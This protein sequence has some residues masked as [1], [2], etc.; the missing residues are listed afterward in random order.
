MFFR[1]KYSKSGYVLQ[2]LESYR[3]K[4]NQPRSKVI[5][6]LGSA[7]IAK[8]D[9]N[10]IARGIE[11]H[12]SGALE[13][14]PERFPVRIQKW[15]DRLIKQ[16][17]RK[18]RYTSHLSSKTQANTDAE[19][20]RG[21]LKPVVIPGVL[22]REVT[23]SHTTSLG[24]ELI[25]HQA[26]QH[27]RMDELLHRLGFNDTQIR[28]ATVS[29]INRLIDPVSEHVLPQWVLNTS[30]PELL[31]KGVQG[32]GK[33]R[34][35]RVSD[36]LLQ[37]KERIEAH[38]R[39]QQKEL[40]HLERTV[41][42]YDLTNSH[43]E[44]NCARNPKAKRGKNKQKRDDCL[45]IVVGML[46]DAH[47]FE[48]GHKIFEGNQND[49][50]S[51]LTMIDE[52]DRMHAAK[53]KGLDSLIKPLVV[54]D[55]GVATRANLK[56]LRDKKYSYLVNDSRRARKKY[57][58]Q[59]Q[60]EH[61]FEVIRDRKKK[62]EV[63]VCQI[64]DPAMMEDPTED[65]V[66]A[67]NTVEMENSPADRLLLCKSDK[68]REKELAMLSNA[69]KHFLAALQKLATRIEKGHLVDADKIQRCLGGIQNKH[70]R[71]QRHYHLSYEAYRPKAAPR[72]PAGKLTWIRQ[73]DSYSAD[74]ALLGCYVLRTNCR[75]FSSQEFWK[76]YMAL[77]HAEN[78][79]R[80]LKSNLG[81]RPNRHHVEDRVDAHVFI[82]ILAYDLLRTIL[83][84]LESKGDHRSWETIKRIMQT[85]CYTTMII[86]TNDGKV[87]RIRKPGE[88]EQGQR[89]IYH[90]LGVTLNNLP[91]M[92][93]IAPEDNM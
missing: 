83:Y 91:I 5:L 31:G 58:A 18:G 14:F 69:E 35:Y 86:P 6:S 9:W 40:F 56:L 59:F 47:G 84:R 44:G 45:Q 68:R 74:D 62:G 41:V 29:V 43:F 53:Q 89:D 78:G 10:A 77:L 46:L 36:K 8:K 80:S 79:F 49:A 3:N 24:P 93:H 19:G 66:S 28:I 55:A 76:L 2:L 65:D 71:V 75:D 85:H 64:D 39:Q 33:D 27:L 92:N 15:T 63:N 20:T 16:I 70:P 57:L 26:W 11:H 23:H 67:D 4:Q 34:Y 61:A 22:L 82:T 48:L 52:L 7:R 60:N 73:E 88:P 38:I 87:Y 51:L 12:Y 37:H 81:L 21:D 90:K 25:A 32:S 50:K 54:M 1:K 30:L 17:E 72:S 13:L 42:L